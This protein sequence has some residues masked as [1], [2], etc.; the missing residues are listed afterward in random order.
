M[1]WLSSDLEQDMKMY[2]FL[3]TDSQLFDGWHISLTV[4]VLS[5]PAQNRKP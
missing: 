2:A 5:G 3:A 4:C 1:S